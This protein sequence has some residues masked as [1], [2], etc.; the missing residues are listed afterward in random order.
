M[1]W[2]ALSI[3]PWTEVRYDKGVTAAH[4]QFV[5]AQVA[6]AAAALAAAKSGT[7]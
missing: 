3:S 5:D 2:R 1:T 7:D 6:A 4:F